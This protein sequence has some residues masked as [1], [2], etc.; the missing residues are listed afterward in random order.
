MRDDDFG[1]WS[2]SEERKKGWHRWWDDAAIRAAL[3]TTGLKVLFERVLTPQ[4]FDPI[5]GTWT[6]SPH[7]TRDYHN[8][9]PGF[10]QRLCLKDKGA[11]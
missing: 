8:T 10:R 9:P 6:G 2:N 3:L 11:N 7:P 4:D 5:P 1:L